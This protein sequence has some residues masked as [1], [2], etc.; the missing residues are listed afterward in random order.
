VL[1]TATLLTR[2]GSQLESCSKREAMRLDG[3]R[4]QLG[5]Q[6][7]PVYKV[8]LG[9]MCWLWPNAPL[10]G[11]AQVTLTVGHVDWRFGD[12]ARDAITRPKATAG[13]E[14]ELHADS[15]KGPLLAR[16]PLTAEVHRDRQNQ[17]HG[18]LAAGN[19]RGVRNLCIFASGDPRAGQWT[20][21]RVALSK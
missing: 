13:G 1:E 11:V 21:S 10:Q 2:D 19:G 18:S 8:S 17:L 5:G 3:H 4:P 12:D 14:F 9:D 16:L 6:P 15:C 20:L 7:R